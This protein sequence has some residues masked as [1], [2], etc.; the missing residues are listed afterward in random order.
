MIQGQDQVKLNALLHYL[1]LKS[2]PIFPKI[3]FFQNKKVI[4]RL[5]TLAP[6]GH[7]AP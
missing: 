7:L 1:N 5:G 6:T 3:C 4:R 2:R